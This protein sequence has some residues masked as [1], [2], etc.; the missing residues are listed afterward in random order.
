MTA[1]RGPSFAAFSADSPVAICTLSSS[2][3][4]ESLSHHAVA[5]KVAIIGPLE[6]ENIGIEQMLSTLLQ[7]PRI[8]SLIVCG[9]ESRGRYQGQALRCLFESG[10]A[11]DG[12]IHGARSRRARIRNLTS[13]QV[14]V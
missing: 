3:L 9:N 5:S 11:M 13:D 8:R 14:D 4:L 6:T 12:S 1:E 7:R 2:D 10:V